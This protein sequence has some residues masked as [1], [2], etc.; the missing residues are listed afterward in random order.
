MTSHNNNNDKNIVLTQPD[1]G[2]M[3]KLQ[4]NGAIIEACIAMLLSKNKFTT[5]YFFSMIRNIFILVMVKTILEDFK[6]FMD[7]FKFTNMDSVRYF[8]QKYKYS[9][10]VY[11]FLLISGK[12]KYNDKNISIDTL[13]PFFEQK[14]IILSQPGKYFFTERTFIIKVIVTPTKITFCLPNV[15]SIITFMDNTIIRKNEEIIY[16]GRTSMY[17]TSIMPSG[18]IKL[19]PTRISRAYPTENY[20]TLEKSIKHNFLVEEIM[21]RQPKPSCINFDGEPGTG[22]TTFGDYIA[23][24]GIFDRIIICNFVPLAA[25]DNKFSDA[26]SNLERIIIQS[27]PKDRKNDEPE[28]I[29]LILDEVDKW[30]SSYLNARIHKLRDETRKK[31][32]TV[33]DKMPMQMEYVEKLT[34]KEEDELKIQLKNEFL[35]QLYNLVDGHMFNDG[36]TYEIIFNTNDFESLFRNTDIKYQALYDRFQRYNFGKIGK[37]D[38]IKYLLWVNEQLKEWTNRDDLT[39]EK[40]DMYNLLVQELC[41]KDE[42][43]LE[44]ILDT[45]KV[46]HRDLHKILKSTHYNINYVVKILSQEINKKNLISDNSDNDNIIINQ[47]NEII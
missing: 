7:K 6:S 18:V 44:N 5:G 40:R 1:Y 19:E 8:Y 35:D 41:L 28:A 14:Q 15:N 2:Q 32:Q 9:E 45:N 29:L 22:K 43:T 34:E 31:K 39:K 25:S 33:S 36:R 46:T 11:D 27:A 38:I 17:K 4:T 16:A 26:M 10:I 24:K 30:L 47:S 20:I 13:T 23:W 12:W 37:N 21:N 3:I 42:N